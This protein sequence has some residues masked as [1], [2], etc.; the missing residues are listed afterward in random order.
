MLLAQE[1]VLE[2]VLAVVCLLACVAELL[3]EG[4]IGLGGRLG[5]GLQDLV[6]EG[7]GRDGRQGGDPALEVVATEGSALAKEPWWGSAGIA[8]KAKRQTVG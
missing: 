3:E 8:G 7:L 1:V 2:R 4:L 6:R 5:A